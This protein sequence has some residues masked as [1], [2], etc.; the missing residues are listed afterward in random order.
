MGWLFWTAA[1]ARDYPVLMG[2]T[3][4]VGAATVI[5]NLL[6]DISYAMLDPRIKYG[7]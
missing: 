5:G 7:S 3:V 2:F 4:V 1:G 6:A